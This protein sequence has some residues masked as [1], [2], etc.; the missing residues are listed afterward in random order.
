MPKAIFL[1][2]L[3]CCILPHPLK[4][5]DPQF[6]HFYT[7]SMLYNPAFAGNVDF[8]RF[9][10]SYRNQWPGIKNNFVSYAAS[11][12]HFF[13]QYNSGIGLQFVSDRAGSGG[14]TNNSA[15][16]MY[17]YQ[18]PINH[19]LAITAGIKGGI[20]YKFLDI[21][22]Y[23][24]ADQIARD[25]MQSQSI[26][27]NGVYDEPLLFPNFGTGVVLHHIDKYWFGL[28]FDHINRPSNGFGD[29]S[30]KLDPSISAQAGWNFPIRDMKYS[31]H[32]TSK[33]TVAALY[34]YMNNWNQLDLGLYYS[35]ISYIFGIWHRGVPFIKTPANTLHRDAIVLLAG[36]SIK[37]F[38]FAYSYD[39]T[40][41]ELFG[42][43]AGSH[44][45]SILLD[46]QRPKQQKRS[47]S[48]PCPKW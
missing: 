23:V 44:E 34:K 27:N 40:T 37:Q 15:N 25:D 30:S 21:E 32:S 41:S 48:I 14:L 11:Y 13:D 16:L 20:H 33:V 4:A 7:N 6:G 43:S 46:L 38:A 39:I 3:S 47:Y 35:D 29:K 42:H 26:S 28:S 1:I 22:K 5:Q 12:Q 45:I 31:K 36:F 18:A 24:F 8:G 9:A 17:A 10:L 19:K 2:L